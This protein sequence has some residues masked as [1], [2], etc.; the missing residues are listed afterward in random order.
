[1]A[2]LPHSHDIPWT[3]NSGLWQ[4]FRESW[5]LLMVAVTLALLSL[6]LEKFF[7]AWLLA[8]VLVLL[9]LGDYRYGLLYDS[10]VALLFVLGAAPLY[11]SVVSLTSAFVGSLLGGGLLY[12]VRQLSHGGLGLGDVKLLAALGPWLGWQN[13][14]LCLLLAS[15]LGA[16]YG[17]VL[18]LR[19]KMTRQGVLPFGPFLALGAVIAFAWGD[20]CWNW[21]EGVY[22]S[23]W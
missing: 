5:C 13:I 20:I 2:Q 19:G 21:W 7:L 9:A 22:V 12:A 16:V 23:I 3:F 15:C 18:L 4:D 14:I 6:P 8:A 1:M 11:M 10:L 17:G